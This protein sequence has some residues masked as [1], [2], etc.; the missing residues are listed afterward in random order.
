MVYLLDTNHLSPIVTIDH[1]L[2]RRILA[3][4][5]A[6]D[7][8]AIITPV[9]FEFLFDIQSVPRVVQNMRIWEKIKADFVY[10]PI[11]QADAEKAVELKVKLRQQGWQL[12]M[13]DAFSA[14]IALRYDLTLLTKDNDFRAIPD[15]KLENWLGLTN[16]G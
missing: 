7:R 12:E 14:A 16:S 13:V 6:G 10:Y 4:F 1:P 3:Q 2:R 11:E 15:L 9:L 5:N 8:F